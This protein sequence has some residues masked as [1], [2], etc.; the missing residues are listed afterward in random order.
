MHAYGE[1]TRDAAKRNLGSRGRGP[2][3]TWGVTKN[4]TLQ[5]SLQYTLIVENDGTIRMTLEA[6]G[7]ARAYGKFV[8][9]GVSGTATKYDTPFQY[10]NKMPPIDSILEWMN[11]KPV[12]LRDLKSGRFVKATPELKRATAFR[13]AKAIKRD[14]VPPLRFAEEGIEYA[15]EKHRRLL[16]HAAAMDVMVYMRNNLNEIPKL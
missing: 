3:K 15:R 11:L 5:K 14:G 4:R 10:T 13:I 1:S 12:R 2:N 7:P 16:G 8:E 9:M 6:T